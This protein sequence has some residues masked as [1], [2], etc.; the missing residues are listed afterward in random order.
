MNPNLQIR[1]HN[2]AQ[3]V[4]SA[5]KDALA[6]PF[7]V[8]RHLFFPPPPSLA[9]VIKGDIDR[10][11]RDIE[12]A[13]R[14]LLRLEYER[15]SWKGVISTSRDRIHRLQSDLEEVPARVLPFER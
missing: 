2:P 5:I 9:E 8:L 11:Y 1:R 3:W 15:E 10:S 13:H 12:H 14:E 4:V 6:F 7:V